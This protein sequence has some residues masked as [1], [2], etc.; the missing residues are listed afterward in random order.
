MDDNSLRQNE[1]FQSLEDKIQTLEEELTAAAEAGLV[2]LKSN[3]ELHEKYE[4]DALYYQT[5]IE[6][7]QQKLM[8]AEVLAFPIFWVV[9]FGFLLKP[10][11]PQCTRNYFYFKGIK[12]TKSH[13]F[14]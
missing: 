7:R 1:S 3:Q 5:Q 6:V 11:P 2:L 10:H 4:K 14:K 9:R 8:K 12:A 13:T